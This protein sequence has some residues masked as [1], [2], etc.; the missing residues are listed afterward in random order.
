MSDFQFLSRLEGQRA[1]QPARQPRSKKEIPGCDVMPGTCDGEYFWSEILGATPDEQFAA[2]QLAKGFMMERFGIDVEDLAESGEILWLNIFADPRSN[3]RARTISGVAVHE[4]GWKVWDQAFIAVAQTEI[5]LG[6]EFQGMTIPASTLLAHGRYF[7]QPSRLDWVDGAPVLTDTGSTFAIHFR[8][9]APMLPAA[10][11]RLPNTGNR[12]FTA[13][14]WGSGVAYA[15]V[16]WSTRDDDSKTGFRN[17]LTF[18]GGDG[19][20]DYVGV[21]AD[22]EI[23]VLP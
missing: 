23:T 9:G 3:Y 12:E 4:Y 5:T 21:E 22:P 1:E 2:E 19:F 16:L 15:S 10:D 14:P 17:L 13:S 18:D 8:S 20:G 7:V 6:S 11:P